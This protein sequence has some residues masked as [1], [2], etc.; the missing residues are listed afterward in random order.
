MYAVLRAAN[1]VPQMRMRIVD[2]PDRNPGVF[3]AVG[4]ATPIMVADEL[5]RFVRIPYG[6]TISAFAAVAAPVV[7]AAASECKA[8]VGWQD[9]IIMSCIP[10]LRFTSFTQAVRI[11]GE[12]VPLVVWGRIE[13]GTI[14]FGMKCTHAFM[15][16]LHISRFFALLGDLLADPDLMREPPRPWVPLPFPGGSL[17]RPDRE[18]RGESPK[19]R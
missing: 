15:D 9:V 14:P 7:A 1:G 8:I 16:G 19:R 17:R 4:A 6:R 12:T 11:R 13:G 2:G 5:Y 3:E 18:A 10:W